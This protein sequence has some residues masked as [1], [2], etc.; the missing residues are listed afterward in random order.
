MVSSC[1]WS[2]LKLILEAFLFRQEKKRNYLQLFANYTYHLHNFENHIQVI[3]MFHI[4]CLSETLGSVNVKFLENWV[5]NHRNPS[6]TKITDLQKPNFKDQHVVL[7]FRSER[8]SATKCGDKA[9]TWNRAC[10]EAV[11]M[12]KWLIGIL[13]SCV[14]FAGVC[15]KATAGTNLHAP[16]AS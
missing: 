7:H 8:W 14:L 13:A 4:F 15:S 1:T 10:N 5:L 11:H 6:E 16:T 2:T 12:S 3:K 9:V